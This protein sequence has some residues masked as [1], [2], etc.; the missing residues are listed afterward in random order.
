MKTEQK[1]VDTTIVQE[2]IKEL[3][4]S[5]GRAM[6]PSKTVMGVTFAAETE[7]LDGAALKGRLAVQASYEG[8]HQDDW[9]D[10]RVFEVTPGDISALA[11]TAPRYRP[12][13]KNFAEEFNRLSAD[14]EKRKNAMLQDMFGKGLGSRTPAPKTARFKNGTTPSAHMP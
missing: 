3:N 10:E 8:M 2:I 14:W 12:D 11:R 4:S 1:G 7:D 13:F 5:S 6:G 9:D